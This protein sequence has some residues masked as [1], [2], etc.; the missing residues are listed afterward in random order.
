MEK[1][2]GPQTWESCIFTN[3]KED[4]ICKFAKNLQLLKWYEKNEDEEET[5]A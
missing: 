3:F 5:D 2:S 1:I 4:L